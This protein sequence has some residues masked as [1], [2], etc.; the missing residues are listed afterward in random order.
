MRV[1]LGVSERSKRFLRDDIEAERD[2]VLFFERSRERFLTERLRL[3]LPPPRP[4]G[5]PFSRLSSFSALWLRPLSLVSPT[6][7]L[8]AG[9]FERDVRRFRRSCPLLDDDDDEL[10]MI[11]LN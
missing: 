10:K 8:R 5:D 3:R 7:A 1:G 4:L 9:L 11:K 6:G 2:L